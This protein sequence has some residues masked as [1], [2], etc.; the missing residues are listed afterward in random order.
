MSHGVVLL[1]SIEISFH[2]G[3]LWYSLRYQFPTL[4]QAH[5]NPPAQ[6]FPV[7]LSNLIIE[8][9]FNMWGIFLSNYK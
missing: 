1:I 5:E 4:F 9:K 7:E 2:F 6:T 8:I 3:F